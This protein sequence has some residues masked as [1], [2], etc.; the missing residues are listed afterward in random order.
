VAGQPPSWFWL[1]T[2]AT[3]HDSPT[4]LSHHRK[5]IRGRRPGFL[6]RL[7]LPPR[8]P[9]ISLTRKG[10]HKGA[11]LTHPAEVWDSKDDAP[12]RGTTEKTAANARSGTARARA[13]TRST[14]RQ[15]GAEDPQRRLQ[16]GSAE[17]SLLE[18]HQTPPPPM[19]RTN[20]S[21]SLSVAA[22]ESKDIV[23]HTQHYTSRP[24]TEVKP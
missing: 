24:P 13:F 10:Q 15:G 14:Q 12:R 16:E 11:R 19:R 5:A 4:T 3:P 2:L 9:P 1:V 20:T 21:R 17:G 7:R 8:L 23:P 18:L 6:H 22:A